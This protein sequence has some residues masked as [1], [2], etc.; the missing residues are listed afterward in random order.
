MLKIVTTKQQKNKKS[1]V[2]N[3]LERFEILDKL[4][5]KNRLLKQIYKDEIKEAKEKIREL[6][7]GR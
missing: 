3:K 1:K 4:E 5:I 7:D 2:L 6:K